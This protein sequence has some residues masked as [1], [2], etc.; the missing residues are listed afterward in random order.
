MI[1]APALLMTAALSLTPPATP[2]RAEVVVSGPVVRLGDVADLTG[3]PGAWR[4]AAAGLPIARF[5]PGQRRIVLSG[6]AIAERARGAMPVLAAW[7]APPAA[8][9]AQVTRRASA[10][11][12][13]PEGPCLRALRPIPAGGTVTQTDVEAAR[14]AAA[15]VRLSYDGATGLAR[16]RDDLAAG[17]LLHAPPRRTLSAVRPGQTLTLRAAAGPV[18][19]ERQVEVLRAARPG[20]AVY[21][22]SDDG[23][24]FAAP[25]PM[26]EAAE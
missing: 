21:V 7:I 8:A 2:V 23:A 12:D 6:T 26:A 1:A 25:G 11:A 24:V 5:A 17:D 16:A 10:A 4:V 18:V 15:A 14:C 3:L 13:R 19:V 9:A 22:R 20:A